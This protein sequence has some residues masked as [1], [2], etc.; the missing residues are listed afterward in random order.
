MNRRAALKQQILR[1]LLLHRRATRPEL[2]A[3]TGTRAATV[4]A[5]IGELK[6]A[7]WV[8]EPERRGKSTGRRAPGLEIS[9][10]CVHTLGVQLRSSGWVG[11]ILDGS[12]R[13]IG[14][15]RAEA[16]FRGGLDGVKREILLLLQK[17]RDRA[18]DGWASVR[19]VGFALP[20]RMSA[21]RGA[22][23]NEY[24]TRFATYC[25]R[26]VQNAILS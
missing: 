12:G 13:V 19:G 23:K 11:V 15:C 8:V 10:N 17:L 5:A 18:G 7:G 4:F 6:E 16:E 2:V 24:G 3:L 20:E 21:E 14:E 22:F 1:H 9:P 25:A 26:C